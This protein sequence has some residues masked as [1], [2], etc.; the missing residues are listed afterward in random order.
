MKQIGPNRT[1]DRCDST[2]DLARVLGEEGYPH[3]TWISTRIQEKGRGRLGRKWESLEG[4]LFLSIILRIE[5]KKLWTWIPMTIAIGVSSAIQKVLPQFQTPVRVKWPNDVWIDGKKAGGILCEAVGGKTDSFIIAGIGL[6]CAYTIEG[7]DQETTSLSA[8]T[9]IT[10]TA[11]LVREFVRE[12]V[13]SSL[14]ELNKKGKNWI[15]SK[16]SEIAELPVG[17]EIQWGDQGSGTV[18]GLGDLGELL[19]KDGSGSEIRLYAE[20]VTKKVRKRKT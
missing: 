7:L 17:S 2:N 18:L 11:D 14:D 16:Y 1:L 6:N 8:Q 13:L 12:E 20:D 5:D 4:N 15:V 10:V 3:G 9:G 19:V